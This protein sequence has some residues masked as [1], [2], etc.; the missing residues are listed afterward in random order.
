MVAQQSKGLFIPY[1]LLAA[2]LLVGGAVLS[3]VIAVQVQVSNLNQ[4]VTN[5]N[6]T[7]LMRD[8]DFRQQLHDAQEKNAQLEVY[9]HDD[10]EKFAAERENLKNIESK[11]GISRRTQ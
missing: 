6:T 7:I 8:N 3:F 9:L 5:L 10:R 4:Q 2:L 11:L 1:P